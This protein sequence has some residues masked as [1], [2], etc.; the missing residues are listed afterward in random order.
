MSAKKGKIS[1]TNNDLE[2]II[3]STSATSRS[4]QDAVRSKRMDH[5]ETSDNIDR[6]L[7]FLEDELRNISDPRKLNLIKRKII[8]IVFQHTD[9]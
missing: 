9:T 8:C 3:G 5:D 7:G 4:T 2:D 1:Y 6:F